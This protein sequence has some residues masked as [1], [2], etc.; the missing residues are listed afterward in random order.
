MTYSSSLSSSSAFQNRS[1][2]QGRRG[3]F[4]E[5][6]VYKGLLGAGAG[7]MPNPGRW[8]L[9]SS[10]WHLS[11]LLCFAPVSSFAQPL[12]I[13]KAPLSKPGSK[14]VEPV[15]K[16]VN[17]NR[18]TSEE[19]QTLPGIGPATAQR[20]LDYRKKNPPFRKIDEL[21]II[22]GISRVRLEKIRGRIS[23]E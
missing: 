11:L 17:I 1:G 22:R 7:W 10:I 5:T 16:R 4:S 13:C 9:A 23:L 8:I 14:F 15:S 21:L 20:I 3:R 6:R 12:S 18:A 2:R 19:L